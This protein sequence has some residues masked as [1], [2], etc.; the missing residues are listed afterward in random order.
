MKI[1]A[2]TGVFCYTEETRKVWHMQ[3]SI[4]VSEQIR[5]IRKHLGLTQRAFAQKVGIPLTSLQ[6]YETNN[7]Q[8]TM[9]IL[10]KMALAIGMDVEEFLFTNPS[11]SR[12][13]FWTADLENK[14]KQVGCSVGYY[15]EDAY[16]WIDFPD[17][18]LEVTEEELL[19][20][21]EST[22]AFLRFKLDELKKRN[23]N[24]FKPNLDNSKD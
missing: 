12:S 14:L 19:D 16:L 8:P 3:D 15:E 9:D 6:R 24:L 20:L 18:S 22:N 23:S 13:H 21:H 17:G 1:V 10:N 2:R 4:N 7:R 11:T 5:K